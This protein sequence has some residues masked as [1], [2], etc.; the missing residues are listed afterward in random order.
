MI[1]TL[2]N[3][4]LRQLMRGTCLEFFTAIRKRISFLERYISPMHRYERKW[5]KINDVRKIPWH[6][7]TNL[8]MII[9]VIQFLILNNFNNNHI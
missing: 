1:S 5:K 7:Q 8:D 4:N 2:S 6:I 9:V 3:F